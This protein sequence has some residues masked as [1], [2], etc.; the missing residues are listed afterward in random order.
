[1]KMV[2]KA[3]Q[4][5]RK[6]TRLINSDTG[7][8]LVEVILVM[9]LLLIVVAIITLT[10][11]T[12]FKASELV[13]GSSIS[14]RTARVNQYSMARELREATDISKAEN[15]H[16][17]FVSDINSDQEIEDVNYYLQLEGE[18]YALYKQVAGQAG[19]KT[20]DNIIDT[21]L[22]T[23]YNSSQ[24]QID[25][26]VSTDNLENISIIKINLVIR[27]SNDAARDSELSTY[28]SLRNRL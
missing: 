18:T 11:F 24:E 25:D 2:K 28:V 7:Y 20:A 4:V 5:K 9:M 19:I 21:N 22:F 14:E 8:S 6:V 26:P 3:G 23:Y 10:Y 13:I 27:G 17:T 1:M 12:S 16:I 15:S